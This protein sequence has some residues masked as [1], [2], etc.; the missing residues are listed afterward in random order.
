MISKIKNYTKSIDNH[1]SNVPKHL[2]QMY[3]MY[4]IKVFTI[5]P[6]SHH[7]QKYNKKNFFHRLETKTKGHKKMN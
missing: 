6:I 7:H 5:S 2:K 4:Q 1:V 3:T